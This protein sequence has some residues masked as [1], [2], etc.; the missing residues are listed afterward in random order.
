MIRRQKTGKEL[1]PEILLNWLNRLSVRLELEEMEVKLGNP[2][3][4]KIS[5]CIS[6]ETMKV[7]RKII[8]AKKIIANKNEGKPLHAMI[9]FHRCRQGTEIC[10]AAKVLLWCE[11]I[12]RISKR[13]QAAKVPKRESIIVTLSAKKIALTC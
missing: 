7:I 6:C 10:P 12:R 3:P 9:P 13:I 1:A 11:N 8:A 5:Y 2:Q 4:A